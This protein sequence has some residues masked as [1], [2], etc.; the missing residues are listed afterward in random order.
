PVDL[1]E[2]EATEAVR[3][4]CIDQISGPLP[5]DPSEWFQRELQRAPDRLLI[6][7]LAQAAKLVAQARL[8]PKD[9]SALL[10]AAGAP[11][12]PWLSVVALAARCVEVAMHPQ[13]SLWDRQFGKNLARISNHLRDELLAALDHR[14]RIRALLPRDSPTARRYMETY[15]TLNR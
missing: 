10:S 3:L 12:A 14:E 11:K 8:G 5:D 4:A 15:H 6:N 2:A 13:P 7:M 1:G 9:V